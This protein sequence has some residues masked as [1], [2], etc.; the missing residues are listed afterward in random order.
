AHGDVR[1]LCA[2]LVEAAVALGVDLVLGASDDVAGLLVGPA[3]HVT[4]ELIRGRAR[5]LDDPV[6]LLTRVR[7]LRPV[8]GQLA[9][10]LLARLLGA[11]ERSLDLLP[12][13]LQERVHAREH[14]SPHEDEQD[15]ERERADDQLAG[16]RVEVF[17]VADGFLGEDGDQTE[18]PLPPQMMNEN[19][20]PNSASASIRPIPMNIVVRTWFAY[21]GWR[22][23]ASTDLPI[24][25]PRP[26]PG[27]IAASPITSPLPIVFRPGVMSAACARRWN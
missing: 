27:P 5:F 24:R 23:D 25:I 8:V 9:L 19:A 6:R 3:L 1:H 2:Q 13:L 14:P 26:I 10:R 18:H 17:L 15:R 12:P 20:M 22:A 16:V 7:E 21:S 11:L 4:A